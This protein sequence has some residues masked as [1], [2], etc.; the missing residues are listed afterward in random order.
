M[1]CVMK[2]SDKL[3]TKRQRTPPSA[4]LLA[5]S[6]PIFCAMN[7]LSARNRS[8]T[9]GPAFQ[10]ANP[11]RVE[12]ASGEYQVFQGTNQGGI[13]SYAPEVYNFRESWTMWRLADGSFDAEGQ[14]DYESPR[15]EMQRNAF[16]VHLAGDMH[17][18]GV[19]EFR[20]LRWRPDSGPLSCEF[21]PKK[22]LCTSGAKDPSQAI[23]LN[24]PMKDAYGFLWPISA[25]SLS[26]ITRGARKS[27]GKLTSVQLV[28]VEEL[29]KANPVFVS[30]LDGNLK[31]L[32]REEI[33][34]ADRRW[35]AD[36]FELK[37]PLHPPFVIWTSSEGLLLGFAPENQSLTEAGMRL[38]RFEQFASF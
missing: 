10:Q 19:K 18:L 31:Y 38:V 27:A 15:G 36:K 16:F 3:G 6:L 30:V 14:R 4:W 17:A 7:L 21:Q 8:T 29:S 9:N 11:E 5:A 34:L 32:G 26:S 37:I 24:L 20:K 1:D 13:G 2:Q 22:L 12:V 35:R 33:S 25:F 28:T 23:N